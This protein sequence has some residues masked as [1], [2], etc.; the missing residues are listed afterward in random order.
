MS[1]DLSGRPRH[2]NV[3]QFLDVV[4]QMILSDEIERAL[5]MLDNLP[6]YYRDHKP[7]RA[8]QMKKDLLKATWT[9]I[10][11]A[12]DVDETEEAIVE[13]H[14]K[15]YPDSNI[16]DIGD[17]FD[18]PFF[19]VRGNFVETLAKHYNDNSQTPYIFELG[20]ASFWLPSGLK[21]KHYKFTYEATTV[22][23]Q[24]WEYH[25]SKLE[26]VWAPPQDGQ[27]TIF[28]CFEVLEHLYRVEDLLHEYTKLDRDFDHI[29]LSTPKYT[30]LGGQ[31]DDQWRGRELG[32]L[33]T[34]TPEEFMQ[35]GLKWW[36][37]YKWQFYDNAM[38]VM[39]GVRK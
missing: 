10:D 13:K 26:T 35:L 23:R 7:D 8:V 12:K 14:K 29:L 11:Y 32:H 24:A 38:M 25:K 21:K 18:I 27:P 16:Q 34:Y 3:E 1:V 5:W 17:L 20:P 37:N 36:P 19:K 22:Q 2:F 30:L 15:W 6:G 28:V 4:E 33:R 9:I 39:H 31:P